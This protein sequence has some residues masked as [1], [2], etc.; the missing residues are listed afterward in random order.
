MTERY[1]GIWNPSTLENE[2]KK[3][4]SN[5]QLIW[6]KYLHPLLRLEATQWLRSILH[7]P[8]PVLHTSIAASSLN[9]EL[10]AA[11]PQEI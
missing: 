11:F 4:D 10:H 6:G 9:Y 5:G 1:L 2:N 7:V 3:Q 8:V